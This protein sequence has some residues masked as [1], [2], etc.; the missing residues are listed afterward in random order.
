MFGIG[1][2]C[3]KGNDMLSKKDLKEIRTRDFLRRENYYH[4]FDDVKSCLIYGDN[5]EKDVYLTVII[6]VYNHPIEFVKRAMRSALV[7]RSD[8]EYEVLVIDNHNDDMTGIVEAYIREL[9]DKRVV[10]YRNERN[11]G[12]FGNWN[13][14]IELARGKWVTFLHSDD[15]LKD[16]FLHNMMNIIEKH[17]EIDQLACNYKQLNFIKDKIN[18]E[19]EFKGKIGEVNVRKVK[20]TEYF[21]EMYTSV[22]GAVYRKE[23]LMKSGGFRSQSDCIGL[24]DYTLMMYYAYNYNTYLVDEVLY[25]DSWGYND[26]LNTSYWYPQLVADYYMW[27]Y[28]ANKEIWPIRQIYKARARYLLKRRAEDYRS[29]TSW[30]GVPIE[31][32][33]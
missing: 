22:K 6:P 14:G 11:I 24:D 21:Y 2:G 5:A 10:Y 15:F 3:R 26:S 4:D 27:I 8:Y 7:Q 28:F 17:P 1:I 25:L 32:D 29:G 16:N 19:K 33:M 20:Y 31:I 12:V 23:C 9:N 13:R 18:I 30:V